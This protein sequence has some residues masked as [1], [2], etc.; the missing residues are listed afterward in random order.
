MK[1]GAWSRSH[2]PLLHFGTPSVSLEWA[3]LETSNLVCRLIASLQTKNAKVGQNGRGL[4]H[5]TFYNFG[6][7]SVS[8]EWENVK[9]SNLVCGLPSRP[10]NEK[11][12]K[13]GQKGRGLRHVT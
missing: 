1:K 3:K 7:P 9:T 5:I 11:N 4:R 13:V 8:L 10:V 2:D 12:A 6:T